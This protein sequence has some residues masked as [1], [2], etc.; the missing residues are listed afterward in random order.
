MRKR[1]A[2]AALALVASLGGV[3]F[4]PSGAEAVPERERAREDRVLAFAESLAARRALREAELRAG[5]DADPFGQLGRLGLD[6]E[7]LRA[8]VRRAGLHLG[9]LERFDLAGIDAR[10][11]EP[12]ARRCLAQALYYEARN[13]SLT[14]RMAVADVVMNRVES[15]RFPDSVCGVVFQGARRRSGCQFSFTCDGSMEA[16][17]ERRAMAEAELV[18][19][20]VLGGFR[21]ELTDGATNYHADYVRPYWAPTLTGTARI[22]DHLFYRRGAAPTQY[23]MLD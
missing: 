21:L 22:G 17:T 8:A 12:N 23:A 6:G 3:A 4:W 7:G 9:E 13:Q 16:P 11:I 20:A 19:T 5:Q 2:G 10:R 14:G 1:L 18:A 15:A